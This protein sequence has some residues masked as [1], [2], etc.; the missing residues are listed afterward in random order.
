MDILKRSDFNQL[1]CALK[2]NQFQ[3][4][5]PTY[6]DGAIIY[7]EIENENDLPIGWTDHQEPGVY[8]LKKTDQPTLFGYVVGPHTWKKYLYP[9]KLKLFQVQKTKDGFQVFPEN[10]STIPQY[11][12]LGMRPCE[13]KAMEIQD[14]IF[15]EGK[16]VDP[17]YKKRREQA[18]I[19]VTQCIRSASTCFCTSMYSGPKASHG[20]DIALTE[21]VDKN[22]H[23][24]LVEAGSNKGKKVLKDVPLQ[25]AEKNQIEDT[26]QMINNCASNMKKTMNT[27]QVKELLFQNMEHPRWDHVADRCLSCANCTMVCPTCFCSTI[28]DVT[29]LTGENAQRWRKWDSCFSLDFSYSVGGHIRLSTKSRYRQW[30]THKLAGWIDQ[31][32]TSGCVGCGRCISWCPV[33]IDLT[34]EVHAIRETSKSP[35]SASFN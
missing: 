23:Y 26:N 29:D 7:D 24:F 12:F 5:G 27:H 2:R 14:K 32:N 30:L 35:V 33:G 17:T 3:I 20:F 6:R 9:P 15:L 28:E 1:L 22:Q 13:L 10:D 4:I 19:V 11:A 21:V 31:F 18:L 8:R 16:F 34:E 25:P